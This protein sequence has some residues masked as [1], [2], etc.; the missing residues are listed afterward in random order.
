MA[1]SLDQPV[2]IALPT[3]ILDTE[4][5][6]PSITQKSTEGER[7]AAEFTPYLALIQPIADLNRPETSDSEAI[8]TALSLRRKASVSTENGDA[9]NEADKGKSRRNSAQ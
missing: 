6:S 2:T 9:V 3:H 4:P 1:M 5:I 8:V 7:A